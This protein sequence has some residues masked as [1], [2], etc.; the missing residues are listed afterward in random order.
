M[1]C[2]TRSGSCWNVICTALASAALPRPSAPAPP[3]G[4]V[5]AG[6]NVY[7]W[8]QV[9]SNHRPLACK[10]CHHHSPATAEALSTQVSASRGE[11][12][13]AGKRTTELIALPSA[14][15]TSAVG[16]AW[17]GGG[18]LAGRPRG[19]RPCQTWVAPP[20]TG[21]GRRTAITS[22]R[23]KRVHHPRYWR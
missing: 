2:F 17:G 11:Q 21:R 16:T 9:D 6:Q 20:E 14:L 13:R 8:A 3:D 19:P 10:D 12:Q 4:S 1:P 23:G 5:R 22:S 15:P 18:G 7:G